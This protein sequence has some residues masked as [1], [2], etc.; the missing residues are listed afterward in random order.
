VIKFYLYPLE[1]FPSF[2]GPEAKCDFSKVKERKHD[3]FIFALEAMKRHPWRT[4][5]PEESMIAFVPISPDLMA[6]GGC[7]GLRED[8]MLEELRNAIHKSSIFPKKRH[9]F[10]AHDWKAYSIATKVHASLKP[11]SIWAKMEERQDCM[12]SIPYSTNY[13]TYMSMR[14]PN[15]WHLPNP[16]KLGSDRVYSVH[17]V[18]SQGVRNFKIRPGFEDRVALFTSDGG[19]MKDSFIV[20]P[21]GT[22]VLRLEKLLEYELRRCKDV[23][24]TDRCVSQDGFPSRIDTQVAQEKS[25]FTLALRGDSLGSDR[26]VQGM[27]AGTALIHVIEDEK[28]YDWLPFPCTIPWKDILLSIQQDEYRKD[29]VGSVQKVV[30]SVSEKRLLQLQ[31]L[32]FY[33]SADIDWAAYHSRVLENFLRESYFVPCKLFSAVNNYPSDIPLHQQNWC[34]PRIPDEYESF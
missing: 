23:T 34:A 30:S 7:P 19:S 16:A 11:A 32:S 31:K 29:P 4:A 20:T 22:H 3:G 2:W 33:Y 18:A 12:T 28:A 1:L 21:Y 26:W 13:G 17:M 25:N 15:E 5:H 24:D 6:R 14:N 9:V 27:T 10:I 8:A